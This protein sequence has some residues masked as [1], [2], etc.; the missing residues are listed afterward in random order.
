MFRDHY[1][2]GI[3]SYTVFF[4]VSMAV[5]QSGKFIL[6]KPLD[7]NPIVPVKLT[8]IAICF[9]IA[10]LASIWP[11]VDI[12]STSQVIFYRLFAVVNIVLIFLKMYVYSA[13]FGFFAMLPMLGKH[14]GWTHSRITMLLLPAILTIAPYYLQNNTFKLTDLLIIEN[15][16]QLKMILPFYT[17]GLIGY[18]THL[19]IDGILLQFGRRRRKKA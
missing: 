13:F 3:V 11:D 8:E 5:T 10:I 18:A 14:R 1:I 7:W 9:A 2:G 12:K 16:S 6:E 15:L 17:A 19:Q 4:G